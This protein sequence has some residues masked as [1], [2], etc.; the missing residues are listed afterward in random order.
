MSTMSD[1]DFK[2]NVVL[3]FGPPG[4]GKGTIG[5]MICAAGNHYHLSSGQIFRGL[6]PESENG[7]LFY[8]YAHSGVLVPDEITM[9][10][11]WRY[12][13]GLIDTNRYYPTQQILML[14]GV[15]RTAAQAEILKDYVNVLHVIVLELDDEAEILRRIRRRAKIEKRLD[16]GDV[17][18]I[19]Q[20]MIEYHEKT[21]QVLDCYD[22]SLISVFNAN[23][24]PMEVL[25]DVL[26]GCTHVLKQNTQIQPP[27]LK[28]RDQP[29]IILN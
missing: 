5:S 21:R 8:E 3:L 7:K 6:P 2:P 15:P 27:D 28:H 14:D 4:A 12:T 25:R 26:V 24:T 1:L 19:H 17:E 23:Q 16:D 13:C 11:W 18:I 20:R 9:K 22:D 29:P 10:I